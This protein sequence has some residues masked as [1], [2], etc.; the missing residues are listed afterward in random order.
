[1]DLLAH[2]C[3]LG[4]QS[5]GISYTLGSRFPW[6]S[7]HW[8][9]ASP[10]GP[11]FFLSWTVRERP[12]SQWARVSLSIISFPILGIR[13]TTSW[14]HKQTRQCWAVR[15]FIVHSVELAVLQSLCLWSLFLLWVSFPMPC[16]LL[17]DVEL[18]HHHTGEDACG[19]YSYY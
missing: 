15:T 9:S 6:G 19:R 5:L 12:G 13:K 16:S 17:M 1:M 11:D 14:E 4:S 18:K 10:P 3:A 2:I 8:A 7:T